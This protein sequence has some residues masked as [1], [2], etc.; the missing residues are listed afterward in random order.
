MRELD[1]IA[2]AGVG[3]ARMFAAG[4]LQFYVV[5]LIG[6]S[7]NIGVSQWIFSNDP[8]WWV[9]GLA[10]GILGVIWNY[11]AASTFIWRTR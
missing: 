3:E 2:A 1:G 8:I 10:G 9:A 6:A 7:A 5:C 4:L 11:L